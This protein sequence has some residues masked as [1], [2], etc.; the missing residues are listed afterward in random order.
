MNKDRRGRLAVLLEQIE[1]VKSSVEEILS[2]EEEVQ[3]NIPENLWSTEVYERSEAACD[4]LAD[5]VVSLEDVIAS[6][7]DAKE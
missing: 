2:E 3:D 5:A 4:S 1:A 7:E 6:M